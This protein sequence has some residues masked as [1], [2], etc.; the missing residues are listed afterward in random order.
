ML[1]V[2]SY[3]RKLGRIGQ[4]GQR[5]LVMMVEPE[6]L[7]IQTWMEKIFKTSDCD[8][9]LLSRSGGYV[10]DVI[11][12]K[13]V[14]GE[15][16]HHLAVKL[17]KKDYESRRLM[18][19]QA[20]CRREILFYNEILPAF[21][22]LQKEKAVARPFDAV[23]KCYA[24]FIDRNSE[25]I[26]LEN[27]LKRGYEMH[28]GSVPLNVDH[29]KMGLR[30]FAKF[31]ALS[32]ALRD[33]KSDVFEKITANSQHIYRSSVGVMKDIYAGYVG[34][35]LTRLEAAGEHQL[36]KSYQKLV[37]GGAGRLFLDIYDA[38]PKES[39]LTHCDC[40]NNNFFFKYQ[41]NNKLTPVDM[42]I[43]DFQISCLHSPILD[44]SYFWYTAIS[45]NEVP[46]F[47]GLMEFY[48]QE[49][50]DFMDQL[51]T[52]VDQVFPVST[53]W[54]HWDK[55][56]KFG[57]MMASLY[58]DVLL[59]EKE[60]L[61]LEFDANTEAKREL[62]EAYSERLCSIVQHFFKRS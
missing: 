36:S 19:I 20:A 40:H 33:Q 21:N 27:L 7:K 58:M 37:E 22:D 3:L 43:I 28:K 13:V 42:K 29:L 38:E 39:V 47:E 60:E 2:S 15:N 1:G 49:L 51:G 5:S 59:F 55:Y 54:E 24:T 46:H 8:V 11:F 52:N 14:V 34:R 44:L 26:V 25:V 18:P 57:F 10:G 6:M 31:H 56:S 17:G 12:T 32:F 23:P 50:T 45:K 35:V 62:R 9:T 53:L 41:N 16:E 4:T 61:E 30:N 48:H